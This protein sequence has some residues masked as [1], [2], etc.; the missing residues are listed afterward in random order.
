MCAVEGVLLSVI[1]EEDG[2]TT[3]APLGGS[4]VL[5]HL[6]ESCDAHSI[7]GS[8]R[9]SGYGIVMAGK[10]HAIR[11]RFRGAEWGVGTVDFEQN[12]RSFKVYD[13]LVASD[14]GHIRAHVVGQMNVVISLRKRL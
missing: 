3:R 9:G 10:E 2:C 13:A 4:E 6:Q 8:A 12:I 5:R 1:E 11:P 14:V 7:V